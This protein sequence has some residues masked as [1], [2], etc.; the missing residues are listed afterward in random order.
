MP[1]PYRLLG[2]YGSLRANS[3]SSAILAALSE[4]AH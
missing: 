2:V 1:F 3:F 4:A